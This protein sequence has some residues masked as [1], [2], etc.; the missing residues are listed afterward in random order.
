MDI[1]GIGLNHTYGISSGGTSASTAMV[2]GAAALVR[3]RFPNLSA[4]EVI[5]RLTATAIDKGPKGRDDEYGYGIVNLVG[6]LTADVAPLPSGPSGVVNKSY[7]PA[8]AAPK[9]GSSPGRWVVIGL[10]LLVVVVVIVVV[11]IRRRPAG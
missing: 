4:V 3:A 1:A 8:T 7:R 11:A 2:S 6:A 5:H 9:A 10:G